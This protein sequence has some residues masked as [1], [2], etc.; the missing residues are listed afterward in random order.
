MDLHHHNKWHTVRNQSLSTAVAAAAVAAA[1][2]AV[3]RKGE[4][5][6]PFF[7]SH[8]IGNV[9]DTPSPGGMAPGKVES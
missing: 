1:A 8:C 5:E 3:A 4:G 7:F 9:E 2:A 6:E